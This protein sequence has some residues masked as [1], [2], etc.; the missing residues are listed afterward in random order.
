MTTSFFHDNQTIEIEER[1]RHPFHDEDTLTN[2]EA[3]KTM[4]VD[5]LIVED[6][7][8]CSTRL[9]HTLNIT[10][11]YKV[12]AVAHTCADAL[13]Q[14]ENIMPQL[15]IVDLDLPDG[16]GEDLV[17]KFSFHKSCKI[18]V[19]SKLSGSQRV[20]TALKNGAHGFLHKDD[21]E[22][23]IITT[24]KQIGA[25]GAPISPKIAALV[26]QELRGNQSKA[27]QPQVSFTKRE[28]D[29]LK[30]ISKGYSTSEASEMLQLKYNTVSS[31]IKTIYRKLNVNSRC[32]AVFEARQQGLLQETE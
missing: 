9:Y 2:K 20:L 7:I 1:A 27:R 31:Y 32:E 19:Y 14:F 24:L 15:A 10:G 12:M 26:L 11:S 4:I 6:D 23:E 16:K 21:S 29:V 18:L 13:Q 5:T 17:A 8:A 30:M 22:S 28:M 25:G 3:V